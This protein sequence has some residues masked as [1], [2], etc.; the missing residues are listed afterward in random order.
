MTM[1]GTLQI[2]GISRNHRSW[3]RLVP[4]LPQGFSVFHDTEQ[5][6]DM[7]DLVSVFSEGGDV[8]DS[9]GTK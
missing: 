6:E 1:L 2:S 5:S 7:V 8:R 3:E 4:P 9:G